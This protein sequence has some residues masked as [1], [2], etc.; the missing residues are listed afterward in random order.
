M[1]TK[2]E[3]GDRQTADYVLYWKFKFE[4]EVDGEP[5]PY[6]KMGICFERKEVKD[7]H[8]TI[9]QNYDRFDREMDR[10]IRD[11]K[12]RLMIVLI[13]GTLAETIAFIPPARYRGDQVKGMMSAK[14]GAIAS[15]VARGVQV[16]FAGTREASANSI[17]RSVEHFFEK[18][19]E[20]VLREEIKEIRE[21]GEKR[22]CRTNADMPTNNSGSGKPKRVKTEKPNSAKPSGTRRRRS[23]TAKT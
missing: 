20:F 18:N 22:F 19:I 1:R 3:S 16:S 8:G 17:K 4:Q 21:N 15:I 10:F 12:T 23:K 7:F 5:T 11:K 2:V 9:I 6:R 14:L 13:E